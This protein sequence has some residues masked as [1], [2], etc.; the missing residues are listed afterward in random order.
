MALL[1][2][3]SDK[4]HMMEIALVSLLPLTKRSDDAHASHH[5]S[6]DTGWSIRLPTSWR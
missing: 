6:D 4:E 1:D 2:I 5:S 3:S